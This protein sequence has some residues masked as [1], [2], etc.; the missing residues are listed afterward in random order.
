MTYSFSEALA[1]LLA[2]RTTQA[3]SRANSAEL[4]AAIAWLES[5]F[6]EAFVPLLRQATEGLMRGGGIAPAGDADAL[7]PGVG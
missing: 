2:A 5:L 7:A 3:I 1:L 4:A 6:P